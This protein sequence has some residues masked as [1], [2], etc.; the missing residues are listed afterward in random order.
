MTHGL[1]AGRSLYGAWLQMSIFE[2]RNPEQRQAWAPADRVATRREADRRPHWW[3]RLARSEGKQGRKARI[4]RF[5][6][7]FRQ[8]IFGSARPVVGSSPD[9]VGDPVR[10]WRRNAE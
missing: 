8:P 2:I 6:G 5:T 9:R 1:K 7:G 3:S 4:S 10:A